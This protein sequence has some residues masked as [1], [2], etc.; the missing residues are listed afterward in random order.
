[1]GIV[2]ILAVQSIVYNA[3]TIHHVKCAA[4]HFWF[5]TRVALISARTLSTATELIANL[6]CRIA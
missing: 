3:I 2:P 5:T 4:I 6:A 1:M